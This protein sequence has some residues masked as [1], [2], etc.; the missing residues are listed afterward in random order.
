[1]TAREVI[2]ALIPRDWTGEQALRAVNLLQ[3]ATDAI[4][5]LHGDAMAAVLF[6]KRADVPLP[7]PDDDIPF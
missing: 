2:V 6:E 1:M 7:A 5:W 3:Q 4:W